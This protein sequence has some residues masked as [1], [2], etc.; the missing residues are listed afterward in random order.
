MARIH[1]PALSQFARDLVHIQ[2]SLV[3]EGWKMSANGL[4]RIRWRRPAVARIHWSV[5]SQ[6][7]FE[8]GRSDKS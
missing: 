8:T 2:Q 6:L 3:E 1:G 4:Q 5:A 7:A